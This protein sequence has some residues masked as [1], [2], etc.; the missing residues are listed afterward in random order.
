MG[1]FQSNTEKHKQKLNGKTPGWFK[2]WYASEFVPVQ[3]KVNIIMG[4]AIAILVGIIISII[5]GI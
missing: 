1:L 2:D 3:T 5:G 4:M